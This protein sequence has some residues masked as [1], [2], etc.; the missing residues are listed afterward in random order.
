MAPS[1]TIRG[2]D[3][4]LQSLPPITFQKLYQQPAT[5]LAIFR[6]MLPSLAKIFVTTLLYNERP[7]P[8]ADLQSWVRIESYREREDAF[9]KLRRL[10]IIHENGGQITLDPIFKKNFRLALTGGGDH[11]SFGVPVNGE[12]KKKVDIPFLDK[13][14]ASQFD[15]I[16]HYMVEPSGTQQPGQGVKHLLSTSGLMRVSSTASKITQAGF[17]F[18]LQEGNAQI[19][20]LL[21]QYLEMSES[22]GMEKTDVLHFLLML[23]SLELGQAYSVA[24]LTQTQ[25]MMLT[26]LRDYGVVFQRKSTSDRFYPTRLATTLTSDVTGLRTAAAAFSHA[27][28]APSKEPSDDPEERGFIIIE[29]NY[30]VYAYTSSPLAIAILELF[31]KLGSRFPNLI[32]AKLTRGSIQRAIANGITA[33]QIIDYLRVHAHPIMRKNVLI[34]PPTVVDQIRLWQIEGERMKTTPGFLFRD[35]AT[36][37]DFDDTARYAEEVGILAWKDPKKRLMFATRTDQILDYLQRRQAQGG[38][39]AVQAGKKV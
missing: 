3:D 4:Y 24:T 20:V 2:F 7:I 35:F 10:H 17:S 19:W 23:G 34:L 13:Y 15:C 32:T 8:L 26:D 11:H 21:I 25:K 12:D 28:T 31:C 22:L 37:W 16:L 5:A 27:I 6:R 30:R 38:Q 9:I 29:T 1:A 36:Q 33:D 39:A 14:A 18:I